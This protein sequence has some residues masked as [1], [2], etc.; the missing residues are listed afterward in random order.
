LDRV[1][2]ARSR[3]VVDLSAR[4][5]QEIDDWLA[6]A[7][8]LSAHDREALLRVGFYDHDQQLLA[9]LAVGLGEIGDP[10]LRVLAEKMLRRIRELSPI[11]RDLARTTLTRLKAKPAG[12]RWWTP[13]DI[14][15]PANDRTWGEREAR[16][17]AQRR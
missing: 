15:P 5:L 6:L 14:R 13:T 3:L 8:V 9:H 16:L 2:L 12:E 11:Y 4:E 7:K 17:Y 10:D 1:H